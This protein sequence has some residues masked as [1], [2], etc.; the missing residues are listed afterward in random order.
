MQ[1][2]DAPSRLSSIRQR[3]EIPPNMCVDHIAFSNTRLPQVYK[4]AQCCPVL[5]TVYRLTHN[6]WPVSCRQVPRNIHKYWHMRDELTPDNGLLPKG[7]RIIILSAPRES[8][9]H[10]LHE[11][12]TD[13]TKCQLMARSLTTWPDIDRDIEDYLKWCPTCIKLLPTLPAEPLIN[14]D[15]AKGLWCKISSDFTN[16]DN[17]SY[18]LS[19]DYFSK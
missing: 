1:L 4:G 5:F 15:I 8:C 12:H 14:H 10:E 16:W 2:L 18:L 11:E 17:K 19:V 13:I 3:D 7:N 6:G 9:L